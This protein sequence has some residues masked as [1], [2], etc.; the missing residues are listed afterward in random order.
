MVQATLEGAMGSV[1]VNVP[2]GA[3]TSQVLDLGAG[4]LVFIVHQSN[5]QPAAY[6]SIYILSGTKTVYDTGT[7]SEGQASAIMPAGAYTIQAGLAPHNQSVTTT[8]T[9]GATVTVAIK[10]Q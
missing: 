6:T 8:I 3:S 4:T 5:G 1:A 10:L 7:N 2:G 9:P